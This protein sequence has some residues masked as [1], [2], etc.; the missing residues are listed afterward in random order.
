MRLAV[1]SDIHGNVLALEAV[2]ADLERQ[3]IDRVVDLGDRVSGPLWPAE[4]FRRLAALGIEGVRGNHDRIVGENAR[5]GMGPSD[6]FA[7]D[8]LGAVEREALAAL[9][10]S[11]EFAPGVVGFHATPAHDERYLLDDIV[12]GRIVRAPLDKITRRLGPPPARIVLMGHSHRPDMVRLPDGTF[13][14]NPGSVG[15]PGY[16][17]STGQKH[18][19]EAGT[20]HA[21]YAI[22]DLSG[23]ES[24]PDVTFRALAYDCERA[25]RRAADNGR[26]DWAHALRTGFMPRP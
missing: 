23:S 24:M 3:R 13:L 4:T 5:A 1:I 20:P 21:R 16:D 10:F 2:L 6:V 25:A 17:D 26:P 11:R 22:L 19:S 8:A 14:I 15:D 18:V 7:H 12:D 9:P